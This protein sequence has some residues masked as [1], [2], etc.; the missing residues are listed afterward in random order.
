MAEQDRGKPNAVVVLIPSGRERMT[1]EASPRDN[2]ILIILA[3][4]CFVTLGI[5]AGL[6]GVAWPSI[7][8][9]FGLSLDAIAAVL[10]T[11]T[12]G[13]VLAGIL[14]SHGIARGGLVAFVVAALAISITGVLG[15][16]LA[17]AWGVYVLF[18]L[19]A[20]LGSGLIDTGLNIYVAGRLDVRIMNWM[21]ACFGVGASIGPLIMT[22]ILTSGLS[23][24]L[25]YGLVALLQLGLAVAFVPLLRRDFSGTSRTQHHEN[26]TPGENILDRAS[27][28]ETL[29]LLAVWLAIVLFILYTGVESTAGQWT[30]TLFTGARGVS[31]AAAGT[32]TS[33]FWAMLTLGRIV[34]G[35]GAERIGIE[36]LLRLSMTATLLASILVAIPNVWI[37]YTGIAMMGLSLSAIFPTLLSEAPRRVGIRHAANTIGFQMAGASVGFAILPGL[38]GA[39]AARVGLESITWVMI[40]GA[41]L[42]LVL[43]EVAAAVA[44][45]DRSR[46][47]A[48]NLGQPIA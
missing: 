28:R 32:L 10:V 16:A 38:A 9:S 26:E 8:A 15:Y 23:W 34:F 37:G 17:P 31:T 39:L 24:R 12:I 41:F 21:H 47:L 44:R 1:V 4:C 30:F 6:L 25:G 33:V 22:F 18:G 7:Q 46:R 19:L 48:A 13:F 42:M 2:R 43:N 40:I 45:R 3:F 29:R 27:A 20:G 5:S 36:R 35:A 11:S 14:A